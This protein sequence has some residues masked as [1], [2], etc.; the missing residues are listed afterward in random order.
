M[1]YAQVRS[2]APLTWRQR[3]LAALPLLLFSVGAF[4]LAIFFFTSG[5]EL[6]ATQ[7]PL[8]SLFA[9]LGAVTSGGGVA[10]FGVGW[11][12]EAGAALPPIELPV[13]TKSIGSL[14]PN[15]TPSSIVRP[16]YSED[17]FPA[18]PPASAPPY[19]SVPTPPL[20]HVPFGSATP[21][22]GSV[23]SSPA[24]PTPRRPATEME[25]ALSEMQATLE[26]I[27]AEGRGKAIP[28]EVSGRPVAPSRPSADSSAGI[29]RP[30]R[31]GEPPVTGVPRAPP[32]RTPTS[33]AR[34]SSLP[35]CV[36]CG[37]H[38]E[39]DSD[40]RP[41]VVCGRRMC[42]MCELKTLEEG[43]YLVCDTCSVRSGSLSDP[44]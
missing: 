40:A 20:P 37:A 14:P 9:A 34:P 22:L 13:A 21:T 39:S 23:A 16:I 6:G 2:E 41:C 8:W 1:S 38:L 42:W 18:R 27:A 35:G 4:L 36:S 43:R 10:I 26:D 24:G 3:V 28:P 44:Q 19:S 25:R 31:P 17:E 5:A 15:S 7:A 29:L 32:G 12:G 30:A 33:P 11:S